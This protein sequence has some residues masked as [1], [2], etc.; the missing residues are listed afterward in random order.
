MSRE[1]DEID[2]ARRVG[3]PRRVKLFGARAFGRDGGEIR[4]VK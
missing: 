1:T 4:I 3:V 2:D